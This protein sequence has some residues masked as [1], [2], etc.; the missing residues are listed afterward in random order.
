MA[1]V[2]WLIEGRRRPTLGRSLRQ[3]VA[4]LLCSC[5]QIFSQTS[6]SGGSCCRRR[7]TAFSEEFVAETLAEKGWDDY[8]QGVPE[9]S[10]F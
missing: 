9:K 3:L 1:R 4:Q 7:E 8:V 6:R 10:V 5:F 2:R